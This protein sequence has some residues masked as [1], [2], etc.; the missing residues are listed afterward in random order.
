MCGCHGDGITAISMEPDAMD[1]MIESDR[2]ILAVAGRFDRAIA[3]T[4]KGT[5]QLARTQSGVE[6]RVSREAL[7]TEAGRELLETARVAPVHAR[8]IIDPEQSTFTDAD[9][10]RTFSDVHLRAVLLKPADAD[11]AVGWPEIEIAADA[12]VPAPRKRA[13]LWL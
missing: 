6:I 4:D 8:P 12:P 10:L 3:S 9:G 5:L 13:R 7:E 2:N 11:A 1:V